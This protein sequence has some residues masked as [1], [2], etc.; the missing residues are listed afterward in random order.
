MTPDHEDPTEADV[1][2]DEHGAV[3]VEVVE[4]QRLAAIN[5]IAQSLVNVSAA[6]VELA[7]ALSRPVQVNLNH[8]R[9]HKTGEGPAVLVGVTPTVSIAESFISVEPEETPGDGDTGGTPSV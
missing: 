1:H 3:V 8:C 4:A 6:V 2:F 9:I 5:T 7:H